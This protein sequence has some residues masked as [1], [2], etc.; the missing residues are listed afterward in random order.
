MKTTEDVHSWC[1]TYVA[2]K[3]GGAVVYYTKCLR[4]NK[5]KRARELHCNTQMLTQ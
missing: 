2:T 1:D 4:K 5:C 3:T